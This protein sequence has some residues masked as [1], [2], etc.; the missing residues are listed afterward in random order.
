VK[1][2][3]LLKFGDKIECV[4]WNFNQSNWSRDG[5]L[6]EPINSNRKISICEC[7]HLT[8]FAALMDV[9]GQEKPSKIKSVLTIVCSLISSIS[10]LLTI[11][12][13]SLVRALRNR[14]S[15]ITCNLCICLLIVNILVAFG[16]DKTENSVCFSLLFTLFLV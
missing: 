11:G 10:L 4:Y 3:E 9:S 13:L 14:R 16:M 2:N 5:C 12:F 7:N 1:H 6:F 8:N 15:T